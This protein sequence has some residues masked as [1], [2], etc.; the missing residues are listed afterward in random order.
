VIETI[1]QSPSV[2]N[3]VGWSELLL[4]SSLYP[5]SPDCLRAQMNSMRSWYTAKQGLSMIAGRL[6]LRCMYGVGSN[7]ESLRKPL[8]AVLYAI[9]GLR[10]AG[11]VAFS[12]AGSEGALRRTWL[13]SCV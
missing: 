5:F 7:P 3:A 1:P 12:S 9:A 11:S 2:Q 10:K 8:Q 13:Q 6:V 4:L